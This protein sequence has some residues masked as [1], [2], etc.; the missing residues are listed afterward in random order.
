M[1][2]GQRLEHAR[3]S[4]SPWTVGRYASVGF[5]TE[6]GGNSRTDL[7]SPSCASTTLAMISARHQPKVA[8]CR[9]PVRWFQFALMTTSARLVAG[10]TTTMA[11]LRSTVNLAP[12][13][14]GTFFMKAASAEGGHRGRDRHER[15]SAAGQQAVRA[16]P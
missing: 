16:G 11:L 2:T 9:G 1:Q 4:S 5:A 12:T 3:S 7:R 13:S 14:F 10:A 6:I 15:L 8:H